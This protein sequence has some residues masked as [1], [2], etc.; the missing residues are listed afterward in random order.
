MGC[1]Y[2]SPPEE[3]SLRRSVLAPVRTARL[4]L[5]RGHLA[6]VHTHVEMCFREGTLEPKALEGGPGCA[7][8][9]VLDPPQ[10]LGG[11]PFTTLTWDWCRARREQAEGWPSGSAG[12]SCF[13][14]PRVLGWEQ[15]PELLLSQD[16]LTSGDR[17][18]AQAQR[19]LPVL[20]H[21]CLRTSG[22]QPVGGEGGH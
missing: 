13:S 5:S 12:G 15:V 8:P 10:G 18:G 11:K 20:Q 14:E 7:A 19:P 21:R 6:S 22:G 2:S 9:V 3:P 16:W 17:G 1:T 4:P